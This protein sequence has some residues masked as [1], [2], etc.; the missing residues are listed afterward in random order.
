MG[1]MPTFT[2]DGVTYDYLT[3]DAPGAPGVGPVVGVRALAEGGGRGAAG[4]RRDGGRL[5]GGH[6]MGA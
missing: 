3:P 6:A 4:R 5:R 1:G 2:L